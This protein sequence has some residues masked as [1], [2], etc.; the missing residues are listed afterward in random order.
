MELKTPVPLQTHFR[1]QR[2]I[3][4]NKNGGQS[5]TQ[6]DMTLSIQTLMQRSAAGME[7]QGFEPIF[8]GKSNPELIGFENLDKIEKIEFA[9]NYKRYADDQLDDYQ[10]KVKAIE[11][12]AILQSQ[13]EETK[14]L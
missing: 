8:Y 6:P 3:R 14:P 1:G 11:Q 5:K 12:K 7:L 10:A 9:R 2:G 13:A 4:V